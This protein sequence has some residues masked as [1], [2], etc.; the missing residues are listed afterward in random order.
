[1]ASIYT[2]PSMSFID[3]YMNAAKELDRKREAANKQ[4]FEGIGNLAKAGTNAYLWQQRKNDLDKMDAL[5]DEETKLRAELD[6]LWG[7]EDY[8]VGSRSNFDAIMNGLDYNLM[9][10]NGGLF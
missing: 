3:T 5:N 6:M 8:G 4:M 1:M 7:D 2:A 9:P 10:H